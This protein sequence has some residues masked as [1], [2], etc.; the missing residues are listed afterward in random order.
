MIIKKTLLA[1]LVGLS[2]NVNAKN[3]DE[4]SV[5]K[6][7]VTSDF[8][9]QDIQSLAASVS[10]FGQQD[11]ESQ[12][13][14]HI[15]E[16]LNLA[17]NL[18]YASGASR[19]RFIQ[20]RG[21]GERSQFAEP[22]NPSVGFIVDDFDMSGL[23][24]IGTLFDVEQVEVLRGPQA[25]EFGAGALAGAIKIKTVD[26]T[27]DQEGKVEVSL[28]E[29]DTWSMGLAFG[30]QI[31]ETLFYRAALQQHKSDGY[32]NNVYLNTSDTDNIDELTTRVKLKY[33]ASEYLT[34]DLN[35]QYFDIDNGYD[36]FSLD[37]DRN[38][39]SDE[40]GVD[41]Q[42]THTLGL[43]SGAVLDWGQL[44]VLLNT[45]SSEMEYSYDEDWTFEGFHPFEYKSFDQY[46]RDRDTNSF[47]LRAVSNTNSNLFNNKTSWVLGAYYKDAEEDLLRNYTFSAGPFSS[48]YQQTNTA[49]YLQTDTK[50][51][52][53]M[54]LRLGLRGDKFAID[55][56]DN[57]G[58]SE[59][60]DE[61]VLGGKLVLDYSLDNATVYASVS[62]GYKAGGFNPDERVVNEK[63]IFQPEFNWNYELGV[64]GNFVDN[65]GFVRLAVFY[66]DRQDTQVSDFAVQKRENNSTAFV[67]VIGNADSGTNYGLELETALQVADNINLSASFGWLDASF[68]GY[69]LAD[70]QFVA[71][72]EQAQAPRYTTNIA[73]VVDIMDNLSWRFEVNA[74]D[75]Y[76]FSD[77]HDE[78]SPSY[79]LVNSSIR[80]DVDQWSVTLWAKNLLDEE[81]LV[82]GFG[83]F[84]NDP[85]DEYETPEPY[86]QLGDGRQVG[87]TAQYQF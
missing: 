58:F 19:G 17:A 50:L 70:G 52:D 61:T 34:F 60:N 68:G 35:Y 12:Q 46:L 45:T 84:S 15:E 32:I 42:E 73:S 86:F 23:V 47:E 59:S 43:K 62:R 39:R 44:V 33:L 76:R 57:S 53:F 27:G 63:R 56:V 4:Q 65:D 74:K 48:I 36:A 16:M 49:V 2:L 14:Q 3:L 24:G 5:E 25:T 37:N 7:T 79:V 30:G 64:K 67:D 28:A 41:R 85:R 9:D 26:A 11:V 22:I 8:R 87:I 75:D 13:A 80:Y 55:Y 82:R 1:S 6:I 66:M 71:K 18:N 31:T 77:G 81:Y 51:S 21:I 20:I 72:Q 10:V 40:P 54:T 38:T 29:K 78:I 83:G 69:T